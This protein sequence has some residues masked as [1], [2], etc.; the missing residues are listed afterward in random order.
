[1]SISMK[2]KRLP[3]AES[4]AAAIAAAR[5]LLLDSGPQG[6]TLKAVAARIGRARL[7]DNVIIEPGSGPADPREE[8][9]PVA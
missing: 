7:I 4:R 5:D 3:P 6:V 9:E 1:M 2:R 8:G